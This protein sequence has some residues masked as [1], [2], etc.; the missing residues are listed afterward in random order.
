MLSF[1]PEKLF[2]V[3]LIA[4]IVLGPDRLPEA[5]RTV[6]RMVATFRRLTSGFKEEVRDALAEPRD[7]FDAALGD[8]GPNR[9]RRPVRQIINSALGPP[10]P[11]AGERAKRPPAPAGPSEPPDESPL[12]DL[13]DD[14]SLN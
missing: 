11:S 12:L 4:F 5:A 10:T 9:V 3:G 8:F 13:P 14:S 7:A 2:I 1:S 6:G